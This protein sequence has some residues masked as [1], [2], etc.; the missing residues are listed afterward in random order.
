MTS[1]FRNPGGIK[2]KEF[3]QRI[4]MSTLGV[5]ISGICVGIFR[6]AA[7]GVDPFQSLM[8]GLNAVIPISFGTLYII[9]NICLLLFSL[10]FDRRKIGLATIINLTLLGY[11]AEYTQKG[12]ALV[13]PS[14]GLPVRVVLLAIGL[15]V[16]CFGSAMYMN[17]NLGVSTYDAISLIISEKQN[18]VKFKF[19]RM[20]SDLICVILGCLLFRTA[21]ATWRE[22]TAAVG[23]ATIITAFF[24][25]PL[26]SRFAE[27]LPDF[28]TNAPASVAPAQ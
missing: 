6:T 23:P 21:G 13:L 5:L 28:R 24:M 2:S 14:P 26:I 10:V 17:A 25:G 4:W 16:L 18:R 15:I 12:I 1:S 11:V 8:S 20:L 7:L 22:I 9:V 19:C 27:K 3:R